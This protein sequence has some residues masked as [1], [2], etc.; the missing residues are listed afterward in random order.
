[1]NKG[2]S[3]RSWFLRI[4]SGFSVFPVVYWSH[5]ILRILFPLDAYLCCRVVQASPAGMLPLWLFVES[6]IGTSLLQ[7]RPTSI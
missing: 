3:Y 4:S 1:M 5:N 7:W 6:L 2:Y